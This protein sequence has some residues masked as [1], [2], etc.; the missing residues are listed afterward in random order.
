MAPVMGLTDCS[1]VT[2]M[3]LFSY[4]RWECASVGTCA[5]EMFLLCLCEKWHCVSVYAG[6]ESY[7]PNPPSEGPMVTGVE[8]GVGLSMA[9]VILAFFLHS[10]ATWSLHSL[11]QFIP[12]SKQDKIMHNMSEQELALT[13]LSTTDFSLNTL[14]CNCNSQTFACSLSGKQMALRSFEGWGRGENCGSGCR[15]FFFFMCC[16][17]QLAVC[18]TENHTTP[19]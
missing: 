18:N 8:L 4:F 7:H 3:L 19:S 5:K 15:L 16:K 17:V 1:H 10:N 14:F 2:C 11:W 13:L 6:N 9:L 12:Q